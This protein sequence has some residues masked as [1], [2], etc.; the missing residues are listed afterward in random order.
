ME[1]QHKRVRILQ[2][3]QYENW[4][5]KYIGKVFEVEET[6]PSSPTRHYLVQRHHSISV[7]D[8]EITLDDADKIDEIDFS[9]KEKPTITEAHIDLAIDI[10]KSLAN[11]KDATGMNIYKVKINN[12][13][14]IEIAYKT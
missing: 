14:E 12:L 3:N 4:Y 6:S 10:R 13:H 11:F 8:C 5:A 9:T 7:F 2:G 1:K